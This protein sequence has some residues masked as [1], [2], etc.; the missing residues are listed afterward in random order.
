[1]RKII[2]GIVIFILIQ[3]PS[4]LAD[5]DDI[6]VNGLELDKLLNFG[7]ALLA[8]GLFILTIIAYKRNKN[9]RLLY[10][11]A[12]FLLFANTLEIFGLNGSPAALRVCARD[13][14][15]PD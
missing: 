3:L 9:K 10:V 4:V 6:F 5:N 8:T 7:S 13:C 14:S 1:M 11:S 12:A 2:W 15:Y